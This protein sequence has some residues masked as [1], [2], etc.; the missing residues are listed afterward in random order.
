MMDDLDLQEH[1]DYSEY[2]GLIS[3]LRDSMEYKEADPGF[4]ETFDERLTRLE[5]ILN[6]HFIIEDRKYDSGKSITH[7]RRN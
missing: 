4:H 2:Y 5:K 1:N 6:L 3:D 7:S